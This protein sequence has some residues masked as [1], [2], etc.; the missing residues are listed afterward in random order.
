MKLTCPVTEMVSD[1]FFMFP[2]EAFDEGDADNESMTTT[3]TTT[4]T[5]MMMT[6]I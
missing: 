1:Q 5:T 6:T 2:Y 4:T 3:T